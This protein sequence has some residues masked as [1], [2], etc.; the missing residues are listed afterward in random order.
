[1][2]LTELLMEFPEVKIL[3]LTYSEWEEISLDNIDRLKRMFPKTWTDIV[4]FTCKEKSFRGKDQSII[5][6]WYFDKFEVFHF[7]ISDSGRRLICCG[8]EH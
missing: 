8:N 7:D 5:N 6:R 3:D 4:Y 1:M 2:T